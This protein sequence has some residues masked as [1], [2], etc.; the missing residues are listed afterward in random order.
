VVDP[1]GDVLLAWIDNGQTKGEFTS[2]LASTVFVDAVTHR[3][4]INYYRL[5]SGVNVAGPRNAVAQTFLDYPGQP[6]WLFMVDA[7]MSWTPQDFYRLLDL[8]DPVHR[9]IVGGVCVGME[10]VGP[11]CSEYST[12]LTVFSVD[13]VKGPMRWDTVPDDSLIK[14]DATGAAFLLVHRSVFEKLKA[15]DPDRYFWAFEEQE[16]VWGDG[17]RAPMGE[18]TT[19]CLRAMLAGFPCH[20]HSAIQPKHY[21]GPLALDLDHH[22]QNQQIS[23][24]TV[25][26]P[27]KGR[28]DLT[29]RL[30]NE[31]K[32]Q[33]GWDRVLVFD[34]GSDEKTR[35]WLRSQTWCDTYDATGWSIH[36]MWNAGI[37]ESLTRHPRVNVTFLNNDLELGDRFLPGLTE[38]LRADI[39]LLAVCPNYD[40]RDGAR[41]IPV[42][43]IAAGR[44]DGTGGLAGYAFMVRGEW[45]RQ[46]GY[47]FPSEAMWWY[48]DTDLALTISAVG[49]RM[50]I[51]RDTTVVHVH[52]GSQT[53]RPDDWYE[54]IA[55]DEAWFHTKWGRYLR[56]AEAAS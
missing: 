9:P 35:D 52:G 53:E 15:E 26:V 12:L 29:S 21:K 37:E 38:A 8:A 40:Q 36:D 7:D 43:G 39:S 11:E 1:Q 28:L 22:R 25:I 13:P 4:L 44:E 32:D 18:D 31:L 46:S 10:Q 24:T 16:F 30:L 48:G 41:V 47:R 19:F 20:V 3:R 6:E 33:G 5:I 27:V 54:Q 56:P 50:G 51:V 34:N 23:K 42:Q 2:S 45:L 55:R 49:G 14:C 17:D